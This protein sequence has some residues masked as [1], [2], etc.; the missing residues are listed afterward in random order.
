LGPEGIKW[1]LDHPDDLSGTGAKPLA[2]FWV[3]HKDKLTVRIETPSSLDSGI[4]SGVCA[5]DKYDDAR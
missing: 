3:T 5:S 4:D 1:L 2:V